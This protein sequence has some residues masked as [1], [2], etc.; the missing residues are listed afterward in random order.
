MRLFDVIEGTLICHFTRIVIG[1]DNVSPAQSFRRSAIHNP[2]F[3]LTRSTRSRS[4]RRL[5]G[6]YGLRRNITIRTSQSFTPLRFLQSETARP[7]AA[8][9]PLGPSALRPSWPCA[10][11][12]SL[13]DFTLRLGRLRALGSGY[14]SRL[15][16]VPRIAK[17]PIFRY[18]PQTRPRSAGGSRALILCQEIKHSGGRAVPLALA[19]FHGIPS[20]AMKIIPVSYSI[21]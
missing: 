7:C 3:N 20:F 4:A 1:T 5:S 14:H 9:P 15:R 11:G 2:R 6:G 21:L 12:P 8:S 18:S 19:C 10:P 17:H 13:R 16:T